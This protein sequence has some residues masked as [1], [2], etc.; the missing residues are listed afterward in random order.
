MEQYKDVIVTVLVA[1]VVRLFEKG[2][3]VDHWKRRVEGLRRELENEKLK[4]C[5]RFINKESEK[6]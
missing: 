2:L 6:E 3:T 1:V 5:K 4:R